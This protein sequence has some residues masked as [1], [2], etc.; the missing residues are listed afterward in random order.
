MDNS[1]VAAGDAFA[2]AGKRRSGLERVSEIVPRTEAGRV[3]EEYMEA[4]KAEEER[5]GRQ[6]NQ[7]PD[8]RIPTATLSWPLA[9]AYHRQAEYGLRLRQ[10]HLRP[11]V[12]VRGQPLQ[13]AEVFEVLLGTVQQ[14]VEGHGLDAV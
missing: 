6:E 9:S 1:S 11:G 5:L 8:Q 3:F 13:V 10:H 2:Y 14:V 7:Q 4:Y 12:L